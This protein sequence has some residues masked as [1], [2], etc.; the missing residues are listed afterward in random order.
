MD[1]V[2]K[3]VSE[4]NTLHGAATGG[5]GA[6]IDLGAHE[7]DGWIAQIEIPFIVGKGDPN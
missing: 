2:S 6:E 4:I 1:L 5:A 3:S 7:F